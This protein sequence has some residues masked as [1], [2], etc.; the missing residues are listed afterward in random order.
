[1]E[2][3]NHALLL[4]RE[5]GRIRVSIYVSSLCHGRFSTRE[6][7]LTHKS[8]FI[9]RQVRRRARRREEGDYGETEQ[10]AWSLE[11]PSR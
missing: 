6:W 1:M 8:S 4:R 2:F 10:K 3:T 7:P 9:S 5:S 11:I